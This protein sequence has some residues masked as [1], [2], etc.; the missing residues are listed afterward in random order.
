[1]KTKMMKAIVATGYGAP[2]VLKL[3]QVEKPQPKENEVLVKVHANSA[4]T[5]DGMM[6]T[7]KPY[8]GRLM[9]GLTKP[10]HAIPGTGFA[11]IVE[12]V[13]ENVTSFKT[14]DR[15]FGETTLGFSTN[16]EFVAVP[17]NGVIL[18]MPENMSYAEGATYGDG[19]V[20]SLNFLKEIAQIKPG[21]KVLIN[22]ASGSLGTAAVQIAKYMGAEVTGVTSTRNVGL[23]KS[24]G[25]DH[26][27][28]YTKKDFTKV[29]ETYDVVFDT[30]G[31]SSFSESK[32]I[33]TESG[34]YVS[35]VLKFS[36]L[37][38]MMRTSVFSKKKAKFSATGLLKEFELRELFAE[39][40]KISKEGKLKTVIDRQYPLEKVAEAHT[41]IAS[42][43]KKGN[44]V[45]I[46]EP[47][48]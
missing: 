6:R 45:I 31:K 5:A 35:P 27:I 24:L 18:P 39:L 15:V 22:G 43:H 48:N 23:V 19:H 34:L 44:V 7:G 32:N 11:G 36:L 25:A 46:V 12:T 14:G 41:Y 8:F 37:L 38:Q 21:Q 47:E 1:M 29:N 33:L 13:G 30:V 10:K 2:N 28:D 4:T 16:A 26:V 20:T 42:G 40:L 9:T 3:Q 17:E